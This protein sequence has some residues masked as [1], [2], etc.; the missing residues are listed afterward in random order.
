MYVCTYVYIYTYMYKNREKDDV[1]YR[2]REWLRRQNGG[3]GGIIVARY[4]T[5]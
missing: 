2:E 1:L 5:Q 3:G 4:D